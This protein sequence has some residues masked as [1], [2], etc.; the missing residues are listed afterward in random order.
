MLRR[1]FAGVMVVV[2]GRCACQLGGPAVLSATLGT[3]ENE[4]TAT[5]GSTGYCFSTKHFSSRLRRFLQTIVKRPFHLQHGRRPAS[6]ARA[7]N[8]TRPSASPPSLAATERFRADDAA[9]SA[10]IDGHCALQSLLSTAPTVRQQR[11]EA[12]LARR[13][14]AERRFAVE[15]RHGRRTSR[16]ISAKRFGEEKNSV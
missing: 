1:R 14:A 3:G 6:A 5:T 11:G 9:Q 10:R 12:R 16:A 13:T 7:S 8:R 15:S 2:F 4:I